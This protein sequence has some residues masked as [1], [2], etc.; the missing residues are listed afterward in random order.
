MVRFARAK[1]IHERRELAHRRRLEELEHRQLDLERVSDL[2]RDLHREQAVAAEVEEAIVDPDLP[3]PE[4]LAP[5]LGQ[6][7]FRLGARLLVGRSEVRA[8]MAIDR[9][10][11][12]RAC[13]GVADP[14]VQ[15]TLQVAGHDEHARS[16]V[17]AEEPEEGV[18]A[19]RR[20]DGLRH[21]LSIR[22]SRA[23][24]GQWVT[25]S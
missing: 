24:T 11:R 21:V 13:V 5:D 9:T 20:P 2:R 22:R 10:A 16:G 14:G 3:H 17:G 8:G 15:P 18:H 23:S 6:R 12:S 7:R 25:T 4:L 19:F 1:L